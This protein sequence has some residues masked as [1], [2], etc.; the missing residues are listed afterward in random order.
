MSEEDWEFRLTACDQ[1]GA[2]A[3]THTGCDLPINA[4][5]A[6]QGWQ[7]RCNSDERRGR[8]IVENYRNLGFEVRL[9]PLNLDDLDE[10]CGACAP[11]LQQ[12]S[13]IYVRKLG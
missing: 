7:W 11:L 2:A 6:A 13:A 8:E 4:E 1:P 9:E 10:N 5:L 3:G 12:I